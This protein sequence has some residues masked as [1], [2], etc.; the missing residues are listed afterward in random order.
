LRFL[1]GKPFIPCFM[2][3]KRIGYRQKMVL[4]NAGYGIRMKIG[5]LEEGRIRSLN[6]KGEWRMYKEKRRIIRKKLKLSL[7]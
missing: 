7:H 6:K 5:N 4:H 1:F 3:G 2:L